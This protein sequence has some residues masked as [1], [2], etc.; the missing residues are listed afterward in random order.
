VQR[1]KYLTRR[2]AAKLEIPGKY[3]KEEV[4]ARQ[5]ALANTVQIVQM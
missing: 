4:P 3:A 1:L 5:G 2:L